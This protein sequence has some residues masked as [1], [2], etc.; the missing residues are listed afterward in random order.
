VALTLSFEKEPK[1]KKY[2][3]I[4]IKSQIDKGLKTKD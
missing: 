3:K 4:K 1:H 2:E